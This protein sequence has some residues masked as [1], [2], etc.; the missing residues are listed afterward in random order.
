MN[1]T[2]TLVLGIIIAL[3]GAFINNFG[4]VLQ[5]RQVNIKAPP[6][7]EAKTVLDIGQFFK[8]PI[9]VLGIL[10]QTI[11]YLPFLLISMELIKITLS[12]PLSNAGF[13]FLVLG[14][15]LVVNE[16]LRGKLEYVGVL[17]LIMGVIT[18][19]LG[20][21]TG[22]V[23]IDIFLGAMGNFWILFGVILMLSVLSL[24][25]LLK[26]K[27]TKRLIFYGLLIGNI[28]A[29]VGIS[30]QWL[31]MGLTEMSHPMGIPLLITGIIGSV[32][33]TIFGILATQEAYKRGQAIYIV[34]FVQIT[35]N[36]FPIL[37]GILVFGQLIN[38]PVFFWVGVI[39]IIVGASLLS[40]FEN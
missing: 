23:T 7:Q 17:V 24:L 25:L 39:S 38:Q 30:I 40:R 26:F 20:D 36:I 22:P 37:A 32:I 2:G 31:T 12:L 6:D 11:I 8:D 13:I 14:L 3:V 33:G 15:I 28:Y 16:K 10:M 34:P 1:G 27:D 5:K 35:I 21:V 29:L 19:A 18:I 4:I 9:W